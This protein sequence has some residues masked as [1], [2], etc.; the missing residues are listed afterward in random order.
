MKFFSRIT[1]EV[2]NASYAL[3][4]RIARIPFAVA[5]DVPYVCQFATPAHAEATLRGTLATVA[6]PEWAQSGADS[7]EQYARWAFTCCGMACTAMALAYFRKQKVTPVELAQDAARFGVYTEKD[8]ALSGMLYRQFA[9]W[10]T[11]YGLRAS[12]YTWL[13]VK[14]IEYAL[15]KGQ[16]VIVSVNPNIR[17]HD[18]AP[19]LQVGGHLILVTG[20]DRDRATITVNNPSGFESTETQKGHTLTEEA[21][22]KYFA[23]RGI[24]LSV[25]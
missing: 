22:K 10:V 6:D 9:M 3:R 23:G 15:A 8:G 1:Q 20:Y 25:V 17:G 12:I 19:A 2:K 5:H 14:D 11:K 18:T 7:P 24:I 16:L 13:S 4:V 21:F